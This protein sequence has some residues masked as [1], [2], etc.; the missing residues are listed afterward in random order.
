MNKKTPAPLVCLQ[1]H[2]KAVNSAYFSP[3]TG[4]Y[5]ITG[6][7]DNS[8][9][10]FDS[11]VISNTSIGC[12]KSLPHN[13]TTGRWLSV[14][15]ATWVPEREDIFMVG[16]MDKIRQI[17]LFDINLNLKLALSD[18]GLTTICSTLCHHPTLNFLVG[19]N[20]SGKVFVY[21]ST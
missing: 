12:I 14:F 15:R 2:S 3:L 11:S 8:I 7:L 9:K 16:S 17:N 20:S 4:N 6:S 10:I 13:M 21:D 19:G 18:D 1:D 5:V